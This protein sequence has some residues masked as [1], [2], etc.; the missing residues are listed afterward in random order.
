VTFCLWLFLLTPMVR[1][2]VDSHAGFA[3]ANVLMLAPYLAVGWAVL[4][5][6]RFLLARGRTAQWPIAILL[7]TIVY[8]FLLAVAHGRLLAGTV[9]LLRWAAPPLLACYIIVRADQWEAIC[10]ELRALALIALPVLSLYALH[11][12]FSP[13]Q[14]DVLWMLNSEMESIGRPLP[15]EIRVFGTMNSP[16][17]LAYYLEALLL[18]TLVLKPP[19]RWINVPLGL[20]ALAVTL[21]RSAWLGLAVGLVLLMARAPMRVRSAVVVMVGATLVLSPL[22]L[23]NA[24]VEKVVYDRIESMSDVGGDKSLTDRVY[25]YRTSVDELMAEPWGQG[26]GVANVASRYA[27]AD[28]RV[29]DGGPVEILLSLGILF[30][31]LYLVMVALLLVAAVMRPMAREGRDLLSA[32]FAIA[33]AQA[34]ALSSVTTVVGEIGVLFWVAIGL[35]LASPSKSA[36]PVVKVYGEGAP[37]IVGRWIDYTNARRPR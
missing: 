12:F 16:A 30:G 7:G 3:Q 9:D 34:L 32:V 4:Q 15:F 2:I 36:R 33:I 13:P 20:G 14:W 35:L 11:Q 29:I 23:T 1:R 5:Q 27:N 8:G 10:H 18:I 37:G 19:L 31:S 22:A 6:P 28:H 25:A 26:L 21:V 24:R 17:S